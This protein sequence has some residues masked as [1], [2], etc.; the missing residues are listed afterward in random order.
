MQYI[1]LDKFVEDKT[2]GYYYIYMPK[3]ELANGSGK[4]YMHRYV[5]SL[6]LGRLIEKNEHVHHMDG[7][8]ANNLESNL[9]ILSAEEH[10]AQHMAERYPPVIVNCTTC[11]KEFTCSASRYKRSKSG[12][13]FCSEDCRAI[14]TRKFEIDR[15]LLMDLVW[16]YPTV[17]VGEILGVSDKAVEKRCKKLEV[18]KPPRGY[19]RKVE[20]GKLS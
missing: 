9:E 19:W 7:N 12:K 8:R 3:H 5:A 18:P 15:D 16:T 17:K 11:N 4:V 20:T 10:I 13:I 6:K 2:I 14:D 1:P